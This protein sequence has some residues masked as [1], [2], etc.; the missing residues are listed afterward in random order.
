[1]TRLDRSV[2]PDRLQKATGSGITLDLGLVVASAEVH[3][4]GQAAGIRM[5]PPWRFDLTPFAK[6]GEN[7][8]EVLVYNALAN[9]YSTIPTRYRGKVASG[10]I[11]PVQM[12]YHLRETL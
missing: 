10:L 5:T 7:Q 8:I 3:G 11:G 12:E 4:N 2:P 6:P 1:M 9:H